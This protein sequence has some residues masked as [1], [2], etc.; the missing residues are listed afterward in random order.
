MKYPPPIPIKIFSII[1]KNRKFTF[2]TKKAAEEK[3]KIFEKKNIEA[4]LFEDYI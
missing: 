4:T 1:T 3:L 2:F